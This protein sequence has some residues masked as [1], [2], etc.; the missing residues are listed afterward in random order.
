MDAVGDDHSG[1]AEALAEVRPGVGV[2]K[3]AVEQL[4]RRG[5]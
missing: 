1:R 4:G 3:E 2:L 5:V